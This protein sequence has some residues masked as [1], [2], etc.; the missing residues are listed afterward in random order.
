MKTQ[1]FFAGHPVFTRDEF[2]AFLDADRPRSV[3]T[4]DSLLAYH[5]Q[6][7]RILRI[8]RGLYAVVQPGPA[9]VMSQISPYLVAAK[10]AD[11][12]VLAYHT[13]LEFYGNAYSVSEHLRYLTRRMTRPVMFSS[14]CFHGVRFPKKLRGKA[15]RIS[16]SGLWKWTESVSG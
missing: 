5:T 7:G 10:M 6:R 3:K 13:A 15:W 14:Y 1:D 8:R 2:T 16:V 12:A 9:S 11:D 4:A